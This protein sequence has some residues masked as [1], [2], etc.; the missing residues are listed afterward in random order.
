MFKKII[1][2]WPVI[3]G[4]LFVFVF[5]NLISLF[6]F[7]HIP[8]IN[9]EIVYVFQAQ[10]FKLGKLYYPSPCGRESFNFTH[11]I[12][13]GK[14]Y[15]QYPP[16]YPILLL[17]GLLLKAPWL[18]NPLFAA[19]SI[20]A[21]Y[22]LGKE[23]YDEKVG[24]LAA[25]LGSIS[26]WL[27]LMSSSMMSHTTC[28]FFTTVFLLFLFRSLKKPSV[29]NGLLAGLGLGMVFLIRPYTALFISIP[30]LILYAARSLKNLRRNL[31]NAAAFVLI[32]ILFIS[33]LLI[34]NY[35]TNGDFLTFG[36]EISHGKA[37][38]IGFGKTGY[39]DIPH[40]V[41]LG[42][43][44]IFEYIKSLNK[45]LF[46]WPLSSLLAL[47]PLC[48]LQKINTE[49]RKKDLILLSGYFSLLA[50]L[51]FFWGTYILIGARMSFEAIP[52]FLLLS[53][54]GLTEAP[55]L[56]LSKFRKIDQNSLKRILVS[57]LIIFTAYAFFIRFPRW[58]WP[59]ETEW[60][61]HGYGNKFA[62][63][64]PNINRT[65]ESLDLKNALVIMKFIYHPIEYFP[66]GWWG[67][68]F[69][70]NDPRL[71]NKII[72]AR[73]RGEENKDL[74]QCFP[75]REFYL[76]LGTLEQGILIPLKEE[77]N[78]LVLGE[79]VLSGRTGKRYVELID[80]PRE[81]YKL[82]SPEY[83]NFIEHI[84]KQSLFIDVDVTYLVDNGKKHINEKDYKKAAFFFEAALQIEKQP[85]VRNQVLNYLVTC[86]LKSGK[87]EE[88]RIITHRLEKR[89]QAKL[90]NIF[91]EKGF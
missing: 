6:I 91:P 88:A 12:N 84:Y 78:K 19:L 25:V 28:M 87:I 54:R 29:K 75:E 10:I 20:I 34:Y 71:K 17:L 22:Y 37:H 26:I 31:K 68:G 44:Q 67:S 48:F 82:Y 23:I 32:G 39:T 38:G 76:Y 27:L 24:R 40:T 58:I 4:A 45:Y 66:Y 79:P 64:T 9:D 70:Y 55:K 35:F 1:I 62:D 36:Y 8:H 11:M 30:F 51:F 7:E 41:Y 74:S 13:N 18:V 63:V 42:F 72:Y 15:S 50:G 59:P 57:V 73:D 33:L 43:T 21:L 61:Y 90:Y 14:W 89:K 86:Y 80:N 69:L 81:F 53:A 83:S 47:I 77:K 5:T 60:Y 49:A 52:I 16:G 56:I 46:G 3:V 85:E 65:L 2:P